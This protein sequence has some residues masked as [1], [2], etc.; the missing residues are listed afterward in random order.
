MLKH[1]VSPNSKNRQRQCYGDRIWINGPL[2]IL[3]T[4]RKRW[5]KVQSTWITWN[6]VPG[7]SL[8]SLIT[9]VLDA[10]IEEGCTFWDSADVY[11]DNEDLLG[12]WYTS[13]SQIS[14]STT[15]NITCAFEGSRG[16]GR[17][18]RYSSPQIWFHTKRDQQYTG[19]YEV[20][21]REVVEAPGSR[22]NR[23]VLFARKIA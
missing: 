22:N 14:Y 19:I 16:R 6:L 23:L 11:G 4:D 5:R 2:C 8:T 15:A 1:H 10:A 21:R 7:Y 9:Q 3:W 12:K 18:T 13:L 20:G 17:G